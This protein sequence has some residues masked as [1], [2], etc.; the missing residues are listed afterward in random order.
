[1]LCNYV[2]RIIFASLQLIVAMKLL[3]H[4]KQSHKCDNIGS[5]VSSVSSV[6]S[7]S[8]VSCV[9]SITGV[10]SVTF[11]CGT[12]GSRNCGV[13]PPGMGGSGHRGHTRAKMSVFALNKAKMDQI[14][15]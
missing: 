11:L 13:L 6:G 8:R 9:S 12:Q 10:S 4:R 1:M 3:L 5:S 7:V 15:P 14:G 2:E